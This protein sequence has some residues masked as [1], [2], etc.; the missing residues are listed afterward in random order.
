MHVVPLNAFSASVIE[1]AGQ[2]AHA[3]VEVVRLCEGRLNDQ[4]VALRERD[5]KLGGNV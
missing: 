3:V 2:S 4:R 1:P 5:A